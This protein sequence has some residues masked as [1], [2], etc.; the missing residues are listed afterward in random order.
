MRVQTEEWQRFVPGVRMYKG[1][2]TLF[3][4]GEKLWR[5]REYNNYNG[6]YLIYNDIERN[7]WEVI[8]VL[9]GVEVIPERAFFLCENVET[10]VMADSVKRI[11]EKAFFNCDKIEAVN[12]S[13][14]LEF[15]GN[16]AFNWCY[17]LT[18]LFIPPSCR[19]IGDCAFQGCNALIIFSV[20]RN[21]SLGR[22]VIA[23]T[24]L[25]QASPFTKSVCASRFVETS[26]LESSP[27]ETI[28][29]DDYEYEESENNT[30]M[31]EEVNDWINSGVT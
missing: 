27:D 12:F 10:V 22:F 7:T 20:P 4:N 21:I 9:P 18:A 2:K 11:E 29:W 3:Y 13:T 6:E 14:N 31:H 5:E 15:T 16:G 28:G 1:K 26:E 19:K 8:I 25:V 30:E 24:A 23:D 17:S